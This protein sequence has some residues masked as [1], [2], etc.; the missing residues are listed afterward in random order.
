MIKAYTAAEMK[1]Y[2][3]LQEM[4]YVMEQIKEAA[5]RGEFD[6]RITLGCHRE[7]KI[8]ILKDLGYEVTPTDYG[9]P[10]II[11]WK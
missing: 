10:Y 7:K 5:D 6:T 4:A 1:T 9:D 3:E 8:K 11:S 2:T